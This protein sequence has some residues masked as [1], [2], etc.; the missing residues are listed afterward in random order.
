MLDLRNNPGGLLDQSLFVSD[1]FL[2]GGEIVSVRERDARRDRVFMAEPGDLSR[3]LPMVV[4]INEGSASASEIVAGALKD[5]SR[6]VIMGRRSFG[7]GSVQVIQPLPV[8]GALRL[9]TARYFAPSGH[10]IQA[11]GV[12]PDIVLTRAQPVDADPAAKMPRE[13]DLP[14]ALDGDTMAERAALATLARESCPQAGPDGED[15]ELGCALA[16][17]HAGSIKVFLDTLGNLALA[18]PAAR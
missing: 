8:E 18:S 7:K 13:A 15:L 5:Q 4:L 14:R 1:A 10:T 3:G 16:Y 9:T 6:A 17:L 11:R 2:E 12:G